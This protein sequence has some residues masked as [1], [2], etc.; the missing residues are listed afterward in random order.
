[1][2]RHFDIAIAGAGQVGLLCAATLSQFMPH[3]KIVLI[4]PRP[5]SVPKDERA[6]ALASAARAML[7]VLGLWEALENDATPIVRMEITDSR[8]EDRVRPIFL[9]FDQPEDGG[10]IAHMVPNRV[11]IDVLQ[12][13]VKKTGITLIEGDS[14]A[15]Q[16]TEG[17]QTR[18]TL[19]SGE[20]LSA[21][22]LIAADGAR[23]ALREAAGIKLSS[24]TYNQ[25]GLVCTVDHEKP[26]HNV[27]IE[28]F[29]PAGPFAIL[30]LAGNRSSLV[31]NEAPAEAA[32]IVDADRQVQ[33]DEIQKRFRQQLGRVTKVGD[34]QSF[35]LGMAL[36]RDYF[37]DRLVLIGDSAHRVHPIAGQGLNLGFGDVAALVECLMAG[38]RLGLGIGSMTQL[39]DYQ[40]WRRFEVT[41]MSALCDVLNRLF[42]NDLTGVRLIRDVGLGLVDRAPFIKRM[43]V[44]QAASNAASM[45]KLLRGLEL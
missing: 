14:I 1:M 12:R 40:R 8:L 7:S 34:V 3:C 15:A 32:R 39:E 30:P 36:A 21:Q 41:K 22:L 10:P 45:P 28:H 11:L 37:K 6:F 23:S 26:H 9:T 31:W 29:L 35:P 44:E 24:W 19:S 2:T 20:E 27:A 42:S 5:L 25:F 33:L 18:I 4:D 38:D 16:Q 17:D 43:L 13:A